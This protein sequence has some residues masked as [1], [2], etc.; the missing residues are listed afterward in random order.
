M[1]VRERLLQFLSSP[2]IAYLFL[3]AG[4]L[5]IFFEIMSP[6][7]FVLGTAGAVLVLCLNF[8]LLAQT[9]GLPIPF[10]AA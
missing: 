6:G 3:M 2:D 10:L 7:G 4:V 1:T 5:A 9:F 8:V